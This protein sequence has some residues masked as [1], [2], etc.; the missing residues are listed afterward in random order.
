MQL[1]IPISRSFALLRNAARDGGEDRKGVAIRW[2]KA[3]FARRDIT[4]AR[5]VGDACRTE[6]TVARCQ[7]SNT[8]C[9]KRPSYFD[10]TG[11]LV[12]RVIVAAFGML[13]AT[14]LWLAK[15]FRTVT[16]HRRALSGDFIHKLRQ[17]C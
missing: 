1:A 10:L 16:N 15:V 14:V 2:R 5:K 8:R 12:L 9:C 7:L 6:V 17:P 13:R 3:V 4:L 11:F